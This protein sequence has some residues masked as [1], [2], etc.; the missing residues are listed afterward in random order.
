[1]PSQGAIKDRQYYGKTQ[2]AAVEKRDE[3]RAKESAG[4]P[5]DAGRA[6]VGEYL[7][8]WLLESVKDSVKCSTYEGYSGLTR[9]RVIPAFRRTKLNNLTTDR[10]RNFRRSKLDEG[11]SPRTI[12][13]LVFLLRKA[14]QQAVEVGCRPRGC[15]QE[16]PPARTP[17]GARPFAGSRLGPLSDPLDLLCHSSNFVFHPFSAPLCQ[18]ALCECAWESAARLLKTA[19]ETRRLRHLSAS[20]RDLPS[21]IFLR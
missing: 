16:R 11:L 17:I 5:F 20:F 3:A 14:L 4:L 21:A 15:L 7:D 12:Q 10:V 18:A 1:V 8:R 2:K 9:R 6:S 13:H 19:S